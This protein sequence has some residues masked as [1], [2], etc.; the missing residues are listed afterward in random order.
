MCVVIEIRC[1]LPVITIYHLVAIPEW[2]NL[3]VHCDISQMFRF[4]VVHGKSVHSLTPSVFCSSTDEGSRCFQS[5][6]VN[7][8]HVCFYMYCRSA[9]L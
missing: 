8:I 6:V 9:C 2:E 3:E 5:T 1:G 7:N 4:E